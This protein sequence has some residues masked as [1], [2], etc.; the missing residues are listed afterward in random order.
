MD[1]FDALAERAGVEVRACYRL[2]T[3]AEVMGTSYQTVR[4]ECAAG[5]LKSFLPKG[6]RQGRVCASADIDEWIREGS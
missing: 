3:V 2:R 1:S 6:R 4:R 5:R